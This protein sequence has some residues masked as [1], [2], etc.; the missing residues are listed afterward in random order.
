MTTLTTYTDRT[1]FN[2]NCYRV[3]WR[4]GAHKQGVF[5]VH[6]CHELDG[7]LEAEMMVIYELLFNRGTL[8]DSRI[9]GKGVKLIVSAGAIHKLVRQKSSKAHLNRIAAPLI[10]HAKDADWEVSQDITWAK[11]AVP[12]EQSLCRRFYIL[13]CAPLNL[14]RSA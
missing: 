14:A 5:E 9:S 10:L 2:E 11:A 12:T 3:H 13:L 4:V 7:R 6:E 1:P 8:G